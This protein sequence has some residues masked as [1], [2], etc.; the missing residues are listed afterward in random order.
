MSPSSVS[1]IVVN[2]NTRDLPLQLLAR[3]SREDGDPQHELELV[4]VDDDSGDGSSEETNFCVRE[5]E[6]GP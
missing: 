1:V 4:V 5:Q 2:W 6:R 3:L